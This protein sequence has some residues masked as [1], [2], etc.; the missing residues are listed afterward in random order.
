M[1]SGRIIVPAV[2][3]R[4]VLGAGAIHPSDAAVWVVSGDPT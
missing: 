4:S 1:T 2:F 3:Y